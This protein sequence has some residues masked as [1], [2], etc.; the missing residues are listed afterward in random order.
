MNA[1]AT[2]LAQSTTRISTIFS[3]RAKVCSSRSTALPS[4]FNTS[5]LLRGITRG[6]K[7]VV[8]VQVLVDSTQK[9]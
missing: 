7:E 1:I 8:S 5:Y 3:R 4:Q 9:V 2:H 6:Q